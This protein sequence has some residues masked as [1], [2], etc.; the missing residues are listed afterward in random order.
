[1]QCVGGEGREEKREGL[2]VGLR[3]SFVSNDSEIFAFRH[4]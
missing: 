4:M 2:A 1:M 3:C